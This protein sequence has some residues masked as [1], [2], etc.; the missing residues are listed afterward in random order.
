MNKIDVGIIIGG[1]LLT[2][3]TF[4][5]V[6]GISS[7]KINHMNED[8]VANVSKNLSAYTQDYNSKLFTTTSALLSD[9]EKNDSTD[10][11]VQVN[12]DSNDGTK[13]TV[14]RNGETVGDSSIKSNQTVNVNVSVDGKGQTSVD[15][16]DPKDEKPVIINGEEVYVSD[17]LTRQKDGTLSYLIQ[18]GDTLC[19]I[20]QLFGYSVQ[21]I[22]EYNHV[23][24]VNLIYA[25]SIMRVPD[26]QSADSSTE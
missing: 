6:I 21:Q 15:M 17:L 7:S 9:K 23:P 16:T 14:K 5:G 1:S 11:T 18:P 26:E 22:A 20:S 3:A 25:D 13:V 19:Y 8:Y 2:I 12:I 4:V 24:D 10:S